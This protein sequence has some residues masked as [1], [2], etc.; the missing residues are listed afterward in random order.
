[1]DTNNRLFESWVNKIDIQEQLKT[2]DLAKNRSVISLLDSTIIDEI[3]E[4]ALAVG[5]TPRQVRVPLEAIS[6]ARKFLE[7]AGVN[8]L[9]MF[10]DYEG[11]RREVRKNYE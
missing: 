9:S 6:D 10:P 5:D 4:Y 1:V 8:S 3:A 2:R 7:L 11:F